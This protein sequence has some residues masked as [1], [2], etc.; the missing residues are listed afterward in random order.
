MQI[1]VEGVLGRGV[2]LMC[3][4]ML[5]QLGSWAADPAFV[6]GSTSYRKETPGSPKLPENP[7]ASASSYEPPW[8][9][10]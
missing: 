3:R 2:V 8:F 5:Q 10:P 9:D 6:I 7:G 1:A 4:V